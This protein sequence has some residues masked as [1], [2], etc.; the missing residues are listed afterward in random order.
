M[1]YRI[2][3]GEKLEAEVVRIATLQYQRAIE[4][5]RDQPDGR[6]RAIHDA[7]KRFKKLRG[8]FRLI[9]SAAPGFYAAENA[10]VRD[11]AA[12]LS[13]ARDATALVEA[14]DHL[15]ESQATAKN[16]D[17]LFAIRA[18]LAERRDRI[19]SEESG[20]EDRIA[21][22][23]AACEDGMAALGELRLPGKPA[24]AMALVAKGT[25]SNYCRAV[26]ALD[27]AVASGAPDDWHELRKRIKYH[28][29]HVQL[30]SPLW[31]GEMGL[32]ADTADLAGE[33]LGDDNDLANLE[34]LIAAEP[35]VIGTDADIALLRACMKN[36]SAD[37]HAQI[38]ALLKNLLKDDRKVVQKRIEALWRDAAG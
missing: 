4:T 28:R 5:L 32:R 10:R 15:I 18:R 6:P 23:I 9:R 14:L 2:R 34:A 1:S 26:R 7:R 20:I 16:H 33:A 21:A 19:A 3:P 38:R 13:S 11:I 12:R 30:L 37:L 25:A 31:P 29:M 22:A 36:R 24:R 27:T 8:L 17:T 35:G